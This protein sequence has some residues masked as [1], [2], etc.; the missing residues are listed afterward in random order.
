GRRGGRGPR[1]VVGGRVHHGSAA[2]VA[3]A[4]LALAEQRALA[5]RAAESERLLAE[6]DRTARSAGAVGV[7]RVAAATSEELA[8]R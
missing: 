2:E 8:G 1:L 4:L 5:G 6:A 7:L 3:A